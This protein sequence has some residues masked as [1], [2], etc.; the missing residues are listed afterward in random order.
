MEESDAVDD[1][2]SAGKEDRRTDYRE[3]IFLNSL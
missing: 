3:E 1:T 2:V